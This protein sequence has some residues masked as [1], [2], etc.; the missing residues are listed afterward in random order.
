[1]NLMNKKNSTQFLLILAFSGFS[2]LF[3]EEPGNVFLLLDRSPYVAA[4]NDVE[5]TVLG[6]YETGDIPTSLFRMQTVYG[7]RENLEV[8]ASV[9][10]A[11]F[12]EPK[13][14]TA[15]SW[16]GS[17]KYDLS[18]HL[19]I[20]VALYPFAS[21]H[22]IFS[23]PYIAPYSGNLPSVYGVLSP[24][25]D[26]SLTLS[27]GAVAFYPFA[28][29]G[30]SS[31]A[32]GSL[33]ISRL[34]FNDYNPVFAQSSYRTRFFLNAA[35]VVFFE[36]GSVLPFDATVAVQNHITWWQD[37][38]YMYDVVPQAAVKPIDSLQLVAG[39]SLPLIGGQVFKIILAGQ[40]TVN[41]RETVRIVNRDLFFPPNKAVLTGAE[42]T[43]SAENEK[44][45]NRLYAQLSRYPEYTIVIEG[46]TSFVNWN[47]PEKGALERKNELIPLS[48]ARAQA[49]VDA[50][51]ERGLKKSR[52]SAVGKAAD[53]PVV[54]F[55]KTD[56]QW[57][58]RRVEIHLYKEKK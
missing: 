24:Y 19:D 21:F 8:G 27:L 50:L 17:V 49:V 3:C 2:Y 34:F 30:F 36:K 40:L 51:V 58:N 37:R 25:T 39:L 9:D 6:T 16:G 12:H 38:G 22:H 7:I 23:E 5:S 46:H 41:T 31:G 56:K 4:F 28:W 44:I 10:G 47:D 33:E 35:P 48:Q 53:E 54:P 26:T 45:L 14:F 32:I 15:A 1:M 52:I 29:K 43:K 13:H 20:P 11:Y 18:A 42:N 55:H 57:K